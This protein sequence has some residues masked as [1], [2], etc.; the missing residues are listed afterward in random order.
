MT[1]SNIEM[2]CIFFVV[3]GVLVLI[4]VTGGMAMGWLP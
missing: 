1:D 3:V 4:V 2:G